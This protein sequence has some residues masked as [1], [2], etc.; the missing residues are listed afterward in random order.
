MSPMNTSRAGSN[1]D[2]DMGTVVC[3]RLHTVCLN[4]CATLEEA[5]EGQTGRGRRL[6]APLP[7]S[8]PSATLSLP[9]NPNRRVLSSQ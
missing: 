9:V 6:R 8:A 7:V 1:P 5:K 2:P 4:P 3:V